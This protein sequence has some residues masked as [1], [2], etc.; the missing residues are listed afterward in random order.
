[1]AC[2]CMNCGEYR[3]EQSESTGKDYCSI[4]MARPVSTLNANES[5]LGADFT[6]SAT[7]T[8]NGAGQRIVA[9]SGSGASITDLPLTLYIRSTGKTQSERQTLLKGHPLIYRRW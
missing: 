6:V 8:K 7:I 9:H 4:H 1:M 3:K 5:P 2:E